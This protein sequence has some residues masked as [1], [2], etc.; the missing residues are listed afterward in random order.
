M[1][2]VVPVAINPLDAIAIARAILDFTKSEIVEEGRTYPETHVISLGAT[3][4]KCMNLEEY[5][6][7]PETAKYFCKHVALELSRKSAKAF[8]HA[9][10]TSADSLEHTIS[11]VLKLSSYQKF[12]SIKAPEVKEIKSVGTL[13]NIHRKL[14]INVCFNGEIK[15]Y[16][17]EQNANTKFSEFKKLA[18]GAVF[19][20]THKITPLVDT[21]FKFK[22]KVIGDTANTLEDLGIEDGSLVEM[23]PKKKSLGW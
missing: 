3:I 13:A 21:N 20:H 8:K 1:H 14:S 23:E 12:S 11:D 10:F 4:E 2:R 16:K 17:L 7:D 6:R 22:E 9:A 5:L 19:C 15:T 18:W